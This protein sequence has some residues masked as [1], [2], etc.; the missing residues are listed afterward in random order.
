MPVMPKTPKEL[1]GMLAGAI[2]TNKERA[3]AVGVRLGF[4]VPGPNGGFWLFDPA[5][6]ELAEYADAALIK[7][8]CTIEMADVDMAALIA[9]PQDGMN[10]YFQGKIKITGEPM[11]ANKL[12]QFFA[13]L[14]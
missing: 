3:K 1:F 12:Q 9:K 7:A 2:V 14:Q 11:A 4:K 13:L 8:N 5:T 10:L 6:P